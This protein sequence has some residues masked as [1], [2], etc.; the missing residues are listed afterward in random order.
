MI[1]GAVA[2]SS[3]IVDAMVE[4]QT[5]GRVEAQTGSARPV[6]RVDIVLVRDFSTCFWQAARGNSAIFKPAIGRCVC[7]WGNL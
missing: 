4:V 7:L 2:L 6:T 3:G 1:Y 5:T